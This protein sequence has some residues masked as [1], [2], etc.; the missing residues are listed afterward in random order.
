MNAFSLR[1]I[2]VARSSHP[3]SLKAPHAEFLPFVYLLNVRSLL[4]TLKHVRTYKKNIVEVCLVMLH[5]FLL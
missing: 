2:S 3:R 4:R 1:G 5:L